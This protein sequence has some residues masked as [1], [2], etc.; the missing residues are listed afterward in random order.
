LREVLARIADHPIHRVA[1]VA[2]EP[3]HARHAPPTTLRRW[4]GD[5]KGR[6]AASRVFSGDQDRLAAAKAEALELKKNLAW[7]S[8]PALQNPEGSLASAA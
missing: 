7:K 1:A 8:Q 3:E 5:L 4:D 6:D 2:L